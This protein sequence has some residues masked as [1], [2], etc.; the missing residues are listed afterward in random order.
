MSRPKSRLFFTMKNWLLIV[1]V[2]FFSCNK[3]QENNLVEQDGSNAEVMQAL[4]KNPET[5]QSVTGDT[6]VDYTF[7]TSL[8][9][10]NEYETFWLKRRKFIPAADT[11]IMFVNAAD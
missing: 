2:V 10:D 7:L 1:V 11:L 9:K 8:Y 5:F 3:K 4:L 6:C